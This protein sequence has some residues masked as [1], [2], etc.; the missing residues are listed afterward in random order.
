MAYNADAPE[1]PEM[2]MKPPG[3]YDL[4]AAQESPELAEIYLQYIAEDLSQGKELSPTA[5]RY[6]ADCWRRVAGGEKLDIAFNLAGKG[7][8]TE[9]TVER[10]ID[11]AGQYCAR[12]NE[13]ELDKDI[14]K[15]FWE[16]CGISESTLS[17]ARCQHGEFC[18]EHVYLWS[19][20]EIL[21]IQ[22]PGEKL[23]NIEKIE[24]YEAGKIRRAEYIEQ[25]K[26]KDMKTDSVVKKKKRQNAPRRILPNTPEQKICSD[27]LLGK[28]KE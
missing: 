23:S 17:A 19:K 22:W 15:D 5:K 4:K 8:R 24:R 25:C 27:W 1:D 6:H 13:G 16:D 26:S 2:Y 14:I 12:E 18:E 10:N 3:D 11:I 7:G 21:D 28:N 20:G 9:S